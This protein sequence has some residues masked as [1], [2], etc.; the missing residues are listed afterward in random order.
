[1]AE[2][3]TT[4]I[5]LASLNQYFPLIKPVILV[6]ILIIIFNFILQ[7]SKRS[8]LK[9][10]KSKKQISNVRI[11]SRLLKYVFLVILI[12]VGISSYAG[13]FTSLGI[14]LGLFSAAIGF[15][16]QRPISGVVAWIMVAVKRPFEI[17]DRIII[18]AF[19]GDVEDI[20][21]THI[22]LKE[23]GGTIPTEENSGRVVLVP[24]STLFEREIV[25]Y[26]LQDEY[27]LS[28]VIA[29]V[30]YEGNLDKA[31]KI[32]LEAAQKYTKE[33]D[34]YVPRK[35]Y[36]RVA[37]DQSGMNVKV[38]FFT[39]ARVMQRVTSDITR[40]IYKKVQKT[41]DVE[42]AYPHTKFVKDNNGNNKINNEDKNAQTTLDL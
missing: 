7:L 37:F 41:K 12:L 35:P 24:N 8:L 33:F 26:T 39:P 14:G 34:K 30:T 15:A 27:I 3:V 22:Y 38:R 10:A 28:E 11:F 36:V 42:L 17:G 2:E 19:K 9:R 6:L 13:S 5:E 4:L 25:N 29:Q 16:L 21:L 1:M 32:A 40:E 20:T 31:M 23:V 18:G